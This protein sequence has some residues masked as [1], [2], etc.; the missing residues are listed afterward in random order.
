MFRPLSGQIEAIKI[1]KILITNDKYIFIRV[2]WDPGGRH[3]SVGIATRYGLDGP[4]IE[5]RWRGEIFRTRPDRCWGPPSLLY[6]GYR[7][8][9]GGKAAGTWCWTSTPIF[10]AEVLNWVELQTLLTLRAVVFCYRENLYLYL[11]L[12]LR[13]QSLSDTVCM[14]IQYVQTSD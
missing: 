3:S 12:I 13:P 11:D 6:S 14:S 7:V 8:F 2:Y 4:G 10:S 9:T 1:Y 5:S